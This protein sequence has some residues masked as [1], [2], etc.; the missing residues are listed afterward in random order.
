MNE[1]EKR[2][3]F[4]GCGRQ[5]HFVHFTRLSA[6]LI[7]FL[8]FAMTENSWWEPRA[9]KIHT[10]VIICK[11][12]SSVDL[13]LYSLWVFLKNPLG[14]T[15]IKYKTLIAVYDKFWPWKGKGVSY[16]KGIETVNDNTLKMKQRKKGNI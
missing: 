9:L 8:G 12:S 2:W 11:G 10:T 13:T 4:V 16:T 1:E 15:C 7:L 3:L 5:I 14:L 6:S